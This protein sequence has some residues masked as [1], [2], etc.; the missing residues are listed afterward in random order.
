[1]E[2]KNDYLNIL[3]QFSEL[4]EDNK[5][6]LRIE[7]LIVINK[8]ELDQ[9]IQMFELENKIEEINKGNFSIQLNG[10]Y[11]ILF[12]NF[13]FQLKNISKNFLLKIRPF[14]KD[15]C[16]TNND[17]SNKI[18]P[19]LSFMNFILVFS[20]EYYTLYNMKKEILINTNNIPDEYL[21]SEFLFVNIINERNRKCSISW[22]YRYFLMK[23]FKE[24][25][26]EIISNK[27]EDKVNSFL[28]KIKNYLKYFKSDFS[29][30][31]L[32]RIM[33][34]DLYLVYNINEKEKRNYHL[35]KYIVHIFNL[36]PSLEEK[37]V[38]Y[39]FCLLNFIN[40][41]LDYSAFSTLINIHLKIGDV[42]GLKKE[43]LKSYLN[44]LKEIFEDKINN[45]YFNKFLEYFID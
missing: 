8:D 9:F 3:T 1:M 24:K 43:E 33:L 15:I 13:K 6:L 12:D 34:L 35:W 11:T 4:F 29:E 26:N 41:P 18:T 21:L 44:Q 7:E 25:L 23:N 32:M 27:Y 40:N 36:Y 5:N 42:I 31:K 2:T 45:S 19:L 17:N 37:T 14:V 28:H 20:P 10:K 16:N 22:E 38:L 30:N 39:I